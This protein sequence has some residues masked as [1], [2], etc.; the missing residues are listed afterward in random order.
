MKIKYLNYMHTISF[1]VLI[2]MVFSIVADNSDVFKDIESPVLYP[3]F[4]LSMFIVGLK[5]TIRIFK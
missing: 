4:L 3:A 1:I 5:F 2:S